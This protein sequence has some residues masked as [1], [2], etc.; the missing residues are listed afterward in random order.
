MFHSMSF[1]F[2][3]RK[4]TESGVTNGERAESAYVGILHTDGMDLNDTASCIADGITNLLHL[5]DR[6]KQDPE[7]IMRIATLNWRDE[8]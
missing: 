4:K 2:K 6:E 5:A 1:K 3:P 7:A 8:R